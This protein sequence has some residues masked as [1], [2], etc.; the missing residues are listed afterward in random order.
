MQKKAFLRNSSRSL[1]NRHNGHL[2]I[3]N[4]CRFLRIKLFEFNITATICCCKVY[5]ALAP[6]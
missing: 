1:A 6:L 4:S 3:C 2:N 5:L